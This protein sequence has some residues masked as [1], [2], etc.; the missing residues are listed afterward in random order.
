MCTF[1]LAPPPSL[2]LGDVDKDGQVA[3]TDILI[4]LGEFGNECTD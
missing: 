1:D 3:V 4:V 2:C